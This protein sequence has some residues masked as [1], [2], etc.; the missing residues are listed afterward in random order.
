MSPTEPLVVTFVC[1]ANICRSAY[2]EVMGRQTL[3]GWPGRIRVQSAGTHGF[4]GEPMCPVMAEEASRRGADP[5]RFRSQRLTRQVVAESDLLLTATS[6]HRTFIVEQS[7]R[8]FR[9]VFTMAQFAQA[10]S[11]APAALSGRALIRHAQQHKPPPWPDGDIAD[12]YRRGEDAAVACAHQI[13][14]LLA[15]VLPRLAG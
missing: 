6:D 13:D 4:A 7:P 14:E 8:A 12:P 10:I 3:L 2:A 11:S 9:S 5:S 1:T 15:A